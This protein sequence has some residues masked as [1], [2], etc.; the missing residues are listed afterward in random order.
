MLSI[1][2]C[3]NILK[4]NGLRLNDSQIKEMRKIAKDALSYFI[5]YR[6]ARGYGNKMAEILVVN[7]KEQINGIPKVKF[8]NINMLIS[9]LV[10]NQDLNFDSYVKINP[11]IETFSLENPFITTHSPQIN[12]EIRIA[13]LL[14][15]ANAKK[16]SVHLSPRAFSLLKK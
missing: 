7:T 3:K 11:K 2:V 16:L 4:E 8:I 1:E 5:L 10:L 6:A 15:D 14:A 9:K 13:A 12:A